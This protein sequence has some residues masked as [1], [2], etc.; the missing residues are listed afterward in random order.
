MDNRRL[1]IQRRW[2]EMT[3]YLKELG[4]AGNI[5]NPLKLNHYIER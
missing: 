5:C 4:Y 2:L 3:K 1:E